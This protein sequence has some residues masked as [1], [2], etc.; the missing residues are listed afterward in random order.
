MGKEDFHELVK[1]INCA[2]KLDRRVVGV[3][4]FFDED[5]FTKADAKKV[6]GK[7]AYCVMV[8]TAMTGRSLK[9]AA[10]NFGCMG[11]ARALGLAELTKCLFRAGSTTPWVSIGTSPLPSR[12]STL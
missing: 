3:K 4:F 7:M 10:E 12:F 8:R 9:A 11:G 1:N 6:T 5:E 2:L